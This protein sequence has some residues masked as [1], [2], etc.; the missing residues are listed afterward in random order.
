MSSVVAH[1][2]SKTEVV[3]LEISETKEIIGI[4]EI[5]LD[6]LRVVIEVAQDLRAEKVTDMIIAIVT[7][8]NH[9]KRKAMNNK[10]VT[11]ML[12]AHKVELINKLEHL[13]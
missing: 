8:E 9:T 10:W 7:A 13:L 11:V 12:W 5:D 4:P 3:I 2:G 6:L 1:L